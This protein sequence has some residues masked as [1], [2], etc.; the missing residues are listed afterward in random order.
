[1]VRPG[2]RGQYVGYVDLVVN[3][4]G[5]IVEYGGRSIVL[6]DKVEKDPAI[7]TL[8]AEMN[9]ESGRAQM[10]GQLL[11]QKEYSRQLEVDRFIG[12]EMCARCHESEYDKWADSA[13]AHAWT[14]L[15]DMNMHETD[16]CVT[17]HVT[18]YG[19]AT[20]FEDY[21]LVP[22]LAGVQCEACHNMGTLHA[23]DGSDRA[24]L[25]ADA[26]V[27]CHDAENSPDFDLTGYLDKI[28]HW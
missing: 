11:K 26:C 24:S 15:V 6:G 25:K 18:G 20:G 13:H 8:V 19:E 27:G 22:N 1:M 16:D 3:P 12:A 14:T 23:V 9:A 21:R 5:E 28:R 4:A 7:L 10:E 2:N 17:C